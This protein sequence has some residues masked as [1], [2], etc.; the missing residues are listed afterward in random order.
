MKDIAHVTSAAKKAGITFTVSGNTVNFT[1]GALKNALLDLRSG[2][3]S[4]DTDHGH[5]ETV[6]GALRQ[7]YSVAKAKAE[8]SK[9]GIM[10][11]SETT[12]AKTGDILL[13]CAMG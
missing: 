10:I 13:A 4:G 11:E 6:L 7:G 5:T 2:A 1:S 3:V 9:Q 12:D 8:M